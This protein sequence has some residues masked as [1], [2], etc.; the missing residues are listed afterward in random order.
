MQ[1]RLSWNIVYTER[2]IKN[3]SSTRD[4][5]KSAKET[6]RFPKRSPK[7]K[8]HKETKFVETSLHLILEIRYPTEYSLIS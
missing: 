3:V 1:P 8:F 6:T 5:G 2:I 4:T 7:Y